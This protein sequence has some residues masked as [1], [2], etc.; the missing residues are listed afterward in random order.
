M[1]DEDFDRFMASQPDLR[2]MAP[3]EL[4]RF[5]DE[6]RP[7][8][9]TPEHEAR[10]LAALPPA[11]PDAPMVVVRSLRLPLELNQR[12]EDAAKTDGVSASAFIRRAV[13][14]ALAGHDR[15]NLVNIEDVIRA[16]RSV[17]PAAA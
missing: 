8:P 9:T 4:R 5:L 13:E 17:P 2:Q 1:S 10:L 12:L 14:S 16:V 3:D 15:T 6:L 11:D 7:M